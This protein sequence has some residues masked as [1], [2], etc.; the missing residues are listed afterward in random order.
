MSCCP[1]TEEQIVD[2]LAFANQDCIEVD[3]QHWTTDT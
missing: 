1:E 3:P 2:S